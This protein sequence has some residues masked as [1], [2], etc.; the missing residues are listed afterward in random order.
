MKYD[1]GYIKRHPELVEETRQRIMNKRK[2][3]GKTPINYDR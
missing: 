3:R 1:E 2:K